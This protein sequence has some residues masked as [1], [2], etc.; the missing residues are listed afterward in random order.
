VSRHQLPA[1][2]P[3]Y[4]VFVGWD[5]P[6]QTY[7]AQVFDGEGEPDEQPFIWLGADGRRVPWLEI[8]AALAPYASVSRELVAVL[9]DDKKQNRG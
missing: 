8:A 5:P 4:E 7:F 3:R 9:L 6:L 1:K 2:N